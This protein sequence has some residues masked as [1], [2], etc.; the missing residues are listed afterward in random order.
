MCGG[1]EEFWRAGK[2]QTLIEGKLLL[3]KESGE[4]DKQEEE[5][6]QW[7]VSGHALWLCEIHA[8]RMPSRK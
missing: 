7:Y 1:G 2:N 6:I 8:C 4:E 3:K 5:D